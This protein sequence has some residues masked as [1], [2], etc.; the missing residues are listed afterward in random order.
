MT[1]KFFI[2]PQSEKFYRG[3]FAFISCQARPRNTYFKNQYF[4]VD[5]YF[6]LNATQGAYSY[7]ARHF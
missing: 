2:L 5:F 7:L 3:Y 1:T 4:K 6:H